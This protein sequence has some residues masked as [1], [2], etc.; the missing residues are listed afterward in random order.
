MIE[1]SGCCLR[2]FV[3]Q[4][5][6]IAT[7]FGPEGRAAVHACPGL[8]AAAPAGLCPGSYDVDLVP[9]AAPSGERLTPGDDAGIAIGVLVAVL[10][11]GVVALYAVKGRSSERAL[12]RA[13]SGLADEDRS[14]YAAAFG[15]EGRMGGALS[16]EG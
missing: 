8:A 9:A 16:V 14:E 11:L 3:D 13:Y 15:A 5:Q 1:G 7:L 12:G 10:L 6:H 4:E 2:N